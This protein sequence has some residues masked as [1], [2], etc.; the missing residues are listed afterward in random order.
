MGWIIS[1]LLLL[2][3]G[4]FVL[5]LSSVFLKD[6]IIHSWIQHIRYKCIPVHHTMIRNRK[7]QVLF[8]NI[9]ETV[10]S[11]FLCQNVKKILSVRS[12]NSFLYSVYL[13]LKETLTLRISPVSY[14][15]LSVCIGS[16]QTFISS[17]L[18]FRIRHIC[19]YRCIMRSKHIC[20]CPLLISC[21]F[22]CSLMPQ[23]DFTAVLCLCVHC[24]LSMKP[25]FVTAC[26]YRN[27]QTSKTCCQ[28][29]PAI[30]V[31]FFLCNRCILR[32]IEYL[33]GNLSSLHRKSLIIFYRYSNLL[34]NCISFQFIQ[35]GYHA[36]SAY[37]FTFQD[38]C[39]KY[40]GMDHHCP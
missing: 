11:V 18:L 33:K 22:S 32:I 39:I 37:Y 7:I 20:C 35:H 14:L 6:L 23:T 19:I 25:F 4:K 5:Y 17:F 12:S 38:L 27:M 1:Q 3:S 21:I 30:L 8:K 10:C 24:F 29:S 34:C 36:I 31:C 16:C 2:I 13:F 40:T 26:S 9:T 28:Y 15:L